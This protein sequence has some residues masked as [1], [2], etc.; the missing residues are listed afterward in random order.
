MKPILGINFF[1]FC[2]L[3]LAIVLYFTKE[4]RDEGFLIIAARLF[5]WHHPKHLECRQV[6]WTNYPQ[7]ELFQKEIKK[8]KINYITI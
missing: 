2:I 3:T 1:I 7:P 6:Q 4:V 8:L 5:N